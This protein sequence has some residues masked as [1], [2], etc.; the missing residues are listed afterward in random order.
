MFDPIVSSQQYPA[1]DNDVYS[2]KIITVK[3]EEIKQEYNGLKKYQD[4][5]TNTVISRDSLNRKL[6]KSGD[7]AIVTA[8]IPNVSKSENIERNKK[9]RKMLIA[10]DMLTYMLL[11][12][13]KDCFS[14]HAERLFLILKPDSLNHNQFMYM[15][16]FYIE[17]FNQKGFI[18]KKNNEYKYLDSNKEVGS[19][20]MDLSIDDIEQKFNKYFNLFQGDFHFEGIEIPSSNMGAFFMRLNKIQYIDYPYPKSLSR[21]IEDPDLIKKRIE[22][23]KEK[24][25]LEK[26]EIINIPSELKDLFLTVPGNTYLD[27]LDFLIKNWKSIKS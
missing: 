14:F 2:D 20:G 25:D 12:T 7:F 18:F 6:E 1:I 9:F 26:I 17:H 8:S 13:Y 10:K 16:G 4:L 3:E 22:K 24:N 5:E 19:F 11:G 27:K 23:Y 21:K 15:L